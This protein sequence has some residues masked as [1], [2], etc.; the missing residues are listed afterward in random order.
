MNDEERKN[1]CYLGDGVYAFFDGYGIWLRT[2]HHEERRCDNK[3][4][5]EPDVLESLNMFVEKATR[6][7]EISADDAHGYVG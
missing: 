3:I 2:G 5:L 7:K 4:Y 6:R 1:Y